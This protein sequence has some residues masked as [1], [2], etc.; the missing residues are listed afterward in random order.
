MGPTH[1]VIADVFSCPALRGGMSE[2][3]EP[4]SVVGRLGWWCFETTTPITEGTYE[5]ARAAVDSR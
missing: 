5:A 3:R 1:D 2:R 4:A